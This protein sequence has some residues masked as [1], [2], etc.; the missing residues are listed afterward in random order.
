VL[1]LLSDLIELTFKLIIALFAL[2]FRLT[3]GMYVGIEGAVHQYRVGQH[4][5]A[6]RGRSQIIAVG[7]LACV[8]CVFY[9]VGK[10]AGA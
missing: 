2:M 7:I 1:G 9:L 8:L 10:F 3:A 5:G 6:T 4:A